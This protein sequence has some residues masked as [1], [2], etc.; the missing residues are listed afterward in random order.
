MEIKGL[1]SNDKKSLPDRKTRGK[2]LRALMDEEAEEDEAFWSTLD[3]KD[4][5]GDIDFTVVD[6]APSSDDELSHSVSNPSF[7]HFSYNF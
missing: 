2:R 1:T 3:F 4:E 5:K 7:L 6:D